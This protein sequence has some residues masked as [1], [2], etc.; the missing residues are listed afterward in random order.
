[1]AR[2]PS[3][4][5]DPQQRRRLR[6]L[7]LGSRPRASAGRR[8]QRKGEI[9]VRP[10]DADRAN[11]AGTRRRRRARPAA[12]RDIAPPMRIAPRSGCFQAG[13]Q[14]QRR[15]LAGAGRAEQHD[16]LAVLDV[17]RQIVDGDDVAE[18]LVKRARDA[19]SAMSG[20]PRVR[21]RSGSRARSPCRTATA[22]R[23]GR[24]SPTRSPTRHVDV[25]GHARPHRAMR[26]VS[27]TICVVPRYSAPNT[28]AAQRRLRRRMH[29]L[30]AH[31]EHQLALRQ[32]P[33]AA[34][35][36]DLGASEPDLRRAPLRDATV[37]AQEIHRRRADE[38][39]DEH[40]CRA[41]RRFRAACRAA[42]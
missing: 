38:V 42:R 25:G 6:H 33:R 32:G 1:M 35:H 14:A 4:L 29:L 17:E 24:S 19:T 15:R 8:A 10:R 20:P 40:G 5:V 9:V 30:R 2:L 22:C 37:E 23:R 21:A 11:I 26:V 12:V 18:A 27:V 16:E 7:A 3:L 31:A 36:G 28:D 13:D 39:G 34:R 41:D